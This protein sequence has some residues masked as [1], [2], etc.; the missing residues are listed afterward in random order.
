MRLI[1]L[2]TLLKN[3][4]LFVFT[5]LRSHRLYFTILFSDIS[6]IRLIDFFVTLPPV[7]AW[8]LSS[9][10]AYLSTTR[11]II[12]LIDFSL[13]FFISVFPP[14]TFTCSR[15][16]DKT[17]FRSFH[18][19]SNVYASG[20]IVAK[21]HLVFYVVFHIYHFANNQFFYFLLILKLTFFDHCY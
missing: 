9:S 15:S 13:S 17:I 16:C 11:N 14:F 1:Y 18:F 6:K 7:Y 2:F 21:I 10:H 12:R 3:L 4:T 19:H 20:L 5:Q 8:L